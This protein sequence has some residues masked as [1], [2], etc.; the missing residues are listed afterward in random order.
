MI[1]AINNYAQ[2]YTHKHTHVCIKTHAYDYSVYMYMRVLFN[3]HTHLQ[4]QHR[5]RHAC[6]TRR[7]FKLWVICTVHPLHPCTPLYTHFHPCTFMYTHVHPCTL[8]YTHVHPYLLPPEMCTLHHSVHI[9][10]HFTY[11]MCTPCTLVYCAITQETWSYIKLYRKII[12][13]LLEVRIRDT[14]VYRQNQCKIDQQWRLAMYIACI[15][16]NNMR[17]Y[18]PQYPTS[19]L[20]RSLFMHLAWCLYS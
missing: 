3:L 7:P 9:C 19:S 4:P 10:I 20:P 14:Q 16:N 8:M 1:I 18:V 6:D 11:I 5:Q 12:I 17:M 13:G 2:L 15:N